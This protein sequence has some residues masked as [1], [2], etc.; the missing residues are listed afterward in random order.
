MALSRRDRY[1]DAVSASAIF[2]DRVMRALPQADAE[3]IRACVGRG[4]LGLVGLLDEPALRNTLAFWPGN[5]AMAR[6]RFG[7]AKTKLRR[8]GAYDDPRTGAVLDAVAS[9]LGRYVNDAN[10]LLVAATVTEDLGAMPR[11]DALHAVATA[12]VDP[13]VCAAW[14]EWDGERM[15]SVLANIGESLDDFSAYDAAL[16]ELEG[17][18]IVVPGE[19]RDRTADAARM[20][21]RAVDCPVPSEYLAAIAEGVR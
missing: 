1:D 6:T 20:I 18:G 10:R 8:A 11:L 7:A 4:L 9:L 21:R 17:N 19:M 5:A 15:L 14:S 12:C 13:V 3:A 2:L 16:V